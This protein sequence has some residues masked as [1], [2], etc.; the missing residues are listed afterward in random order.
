[1]GVVDFASDPPAIWDLFSEI[2]GDLCFDVGANGGMTAALL[3]PRF[4]RVVAYEPAVECVDALSRMPGN[5][6]AVMAAVSD[7]DG[8]I[9][10]DVRDV[11]GKLGELTTGNTMPGAWG[12]VHGHRYVR[13]VTVDSEAERL[14]DPDFIKIDTEGHEAH[15]IRGALG[16]IA[17][18]NPR[19]LIEV[20]DRE[21]GDEIVG[22]LGG[23]FA[24][25]HHPAYVPGS[26]LWENHYWLGRGVGFS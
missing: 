14:G 25:A 1:M 5:V 11:T 24:K 13:S 21:A 12:E 9:A 26:F 18:A 23:R 7:T 17:R 15:V 22:L 2:S 20:H 10:L 8:E 16:T 4:D 6:E 3:S 19:L